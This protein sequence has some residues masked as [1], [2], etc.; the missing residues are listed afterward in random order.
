MGDYVNI[1]TITAELCRRATGST[2]KMIDYQPDATTDEIAHDLRTAYKDWDYAYIHRDDDGEPEVIERIH[3]ADGA[4]VD[5]DAAVMLMD[6]ELREDLHA[7]MVPCT[8]QDFLEAYAKAH[9]EKFGERFAPY[10][11]GAW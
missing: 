11:G 3:D 8:E 9:A 2:M 7:E 10:D 4:P 6:D 5:Y 1:R